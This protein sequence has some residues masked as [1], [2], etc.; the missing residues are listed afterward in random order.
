M[1]ITVNKGIQRSLI[2]NSLIMLTC[3]Y[4][5][6]FDRP[7]T[8][9]YPQKSRRQESRQS[10]FTSTINDLNAWTHALQVGCRIENMSYQH[11]FLVSR[12]HCI[13]RL[14]LKKSAASFLQRC[15]RHHI[16]HVSVDNKNQSMTIKQRIASGICYPLREKGDLI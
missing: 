7:G 13:N 5:L 8:Q 6:I 9:K 3:V 16:K 15:P 11:D 1:Q 2:F 10:V 14:L 4:L 12:I